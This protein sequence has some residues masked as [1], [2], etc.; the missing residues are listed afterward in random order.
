MV[1]A[2]L[3]GGG[4]GVPGTAVGLRGWLNDDACASHGLNRATKDGLDI[5]MGSPGEK[6]MAVEDHFTL[7]D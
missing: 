5:A 3:I 6:G 4:G 2:L 1:A 7:L